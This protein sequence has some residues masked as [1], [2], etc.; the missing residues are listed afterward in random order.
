ML[1]SK[2]LTVALILEMDV[3]GLKGNS[4]TGRDLL[5]DVSTGPRP[6][7]MLTGRKKPGFAL[8]KL[9][10]T[11]RLHQRELGIKEL[12]CRCP[13]EGAMIWAACTHTSS[14]RA[15]LWK[16]LWKHKELSLSLQHPC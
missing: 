3:K 1:T 8:E 16:M 9:F 5:G 15:F 7:K 11:D 6:S 13:I 2:R 14:M 4:Y 10:L 12:T